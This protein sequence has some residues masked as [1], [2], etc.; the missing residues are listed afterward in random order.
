MVN[1]SVTFYFILYIVSITS[2]ILCFDGS[3]CVT[4]FVFVVYMHRTVN[5]KNRLYFFLYNQR[6]LYVCALSVLCYVTLYFSDCE[7]SIFFIRNGLPKIVSIA[8]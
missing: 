6:L 7:L 4:I 5:C 3:V 2:M 1:I 8:V